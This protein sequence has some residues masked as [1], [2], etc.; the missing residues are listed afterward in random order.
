MPVVSYVERMTREELANAIRQDLAD[1]TTW[2][3]RQAN[4]YRMRTHGLRR[5]NKPWPNASDI[6]FP[7][8]DTAIERL[9]P[10]YLQQAY[11]H[12]TIAT[13]EPDSRTAE[14]HVS[15][16]A[17][18][19]DYQLRHRTHFERELLRAIDSMLVSGRGILK[20]WWDSERQRLV[21]SAVRP[22][23]LI[24]PHWTTDLDN[25]DRICHVTHWSVEGF[26]RNPVF[27]AS[28]AEKLAG[29]GPDSADDPET[30][31]RQ[32]RYQREG[33]TYTTENLIVLWE[34]WTPTD[35]GWE[36][37]TISPVCPDETIR[38]AFKSTIPGGAHPFTAFSIE[39][40]EDGWFSPR[41]IVELL[42]AFEAEACKIMNEKNDAMTL[43]NRPYFSAARDGVNTANLRLRPGQILPFGIQ[44]V[45]MP[46]PP[47]SFDG[48]LLMVRDLGERRVS[49]PD[50]GMSQ[51]RST[52]DTRTATEIQAIGATS[53]MSN[54]LRMRVFRMGLAECFRKSWN[55]LRVNATDQLGFW[56]DGAEK[57]LTQ[58]V[59]EATFRVRPSGSADGTD[60]NLQLTRAWN[61]LQQ[62]RG[63][64]FIDQAELR[65]SVL[66]ADDPGLTK[67]LFVDPQLGELTQSEEQAVEISVLRLGFPAAVLPTDNH[68]AHIRTLLSYVKQQVEAQEPPKPAELVNIIAHLEQHLQ[69][70]AKQDPD[71]ARAAQD[72][73]AV[74]ME[75]LQAMGG[76]PQEGGVN[77]PA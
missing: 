50:F 35:D 67:R 51:L 52:Q 25:A 9:K 7:L 1:R 74:T 58:D 56:I 69:L 61:R 17:Q 28:I 23:M 6:H 30:E 49:V 70:L 14:L 34:V 54:D 13:F 36:C 22:Q 53:A 45:P 29:S 20:Q 24:V 75:G 27:N 11:S 42:A 65:K 46:S 21:F 48:Q 40:C 31:S 19:F 5:T 33:L 59:L 12:E 39:E 4:F 57:S 8:C 2:D 62:F 68:A 41:G 63:D 72:A 43:F 3:S 10:H 71:Q 18:W 77:V 66:E 47:V 16:A 44:P 55:I 64:P 15:T 32:A 38:P 26:K 76:Q 37:E 60:R 73:I